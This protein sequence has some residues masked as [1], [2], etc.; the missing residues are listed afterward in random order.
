MS[1]PANTSTSPQSGAP[2][3]IGKRELDERTSVV[4]VGGDLDLLAA[5]NLKWMLVDLLGAGHDRLVVDLTRVSFMDSTAVGVL[6]GVNRS[7]DPGARLALV[8]AQRNVLRIFEASGLDATFTIFDNI[9]DAIAYVQKD[10]GGADDSAEA[11]AT[12]APD[13]A[14]VLGIATTAMPFARTRAQQA[15][16]WLRVLL[17][18]GEV[19]VVLR[20]LG[21]TEA[22][23][24]TADDPAAA[25]SSDPATAPEPDVI[26]RITEDAG[27]V[28]H[29]RGAS[30]VATTD[31]LLAVMHAYGADFNRV[32]MAH[33][34]TADELI[35]RL[36]AGAAGTDAV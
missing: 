6:V 2:V 10:P 36:G 3:V 19:G 35:E 20:G 4:T 27:R 11:I 14:V 1:N 13:A 29:Q 28:A 8:C 9:D 26:A 18:H 32:L 17:L 25:A 33:G 16:R 34:T 22:A 15:E 12:L 7:L 23:E 31:L 24:P 5:P 30:S 21:V